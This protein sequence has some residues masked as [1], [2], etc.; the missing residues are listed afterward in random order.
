MLKQQPQQQ[1]KNTHAPN[2]RQRTENDDDKPERNRPDNIEFTANNKK[3]HRTCMYFS[4]SENVLFCIVYCSPRL[5]FIAL[6]DCLSLPSRKIS[7]RWDKG[8]ESGAIQP[9]SSLVGRRSS[10]AKLR[11]RQTKHAAVDAVA[12]RQTMPLYAQ[13]NRKA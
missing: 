8:I 2:R 5:W 7:S 12:C 3:C 9:L 11:R 13:S 1:R 6:L 10:S 4:L